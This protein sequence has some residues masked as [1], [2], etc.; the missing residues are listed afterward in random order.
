MACCRSRTPWKATRRTAYWLSSAKNYREV[1]F[2]IRPS[3]R[4]E[5]YAGSIAGHDPAS[6][7]AAFE[8][9]FGDGGFVE[10][11]GA[12]GDEA[13]VLEL[14]GGGQREM[15]AGLAAED[16][17]DGRVFGGVRGGEVAVVGAILH[18]FA[19][20]FE[21][22]GGGAGLG[23]D[24][25]EGV[26][27]EAEGVAQPE[28]FGEAGGVDVHDHV[29][30][31]LD[32]SGLAG[33]ADEARGS[34]QVREDGLHAGKD[35]GAAAAHEVEGA[36]AGL[37][38]GGSHAGFEGNGA[39]GAGAALDLE[40]GAGGEGGAVDENFAGG[41]GEKGVAGFGEDGELGGVVGHHGDDDLG[42]GGDGGE[43]Q[44]VGGAEF[45]GEGGGRGGMAIVNG[46]H[47]VAAVVKATGHV[48]AHAT[49]SDEGY[50]LGH[51]RGKIGRCE[52]IGSGKSETIR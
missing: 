29:D 32:L 4:A 19:V 14:G 2:D 21:D 44:G 24:F 23:E 5:A 35:V 40:V 42:G 45:L 39:G 16:P 10:G 7:A 46:D 51:G 1:A 47:E 15:E 3:C 28:A 38:N 27:V 30:E 6:G 25:A 43:R 41:A 18:V 17:G 26:E 20:G 52:G 8:G 31:R 48:G 13:V 37:G 9:E 50:F 34:A 49:D 22:L 33:G 12:E 11:A 36:G